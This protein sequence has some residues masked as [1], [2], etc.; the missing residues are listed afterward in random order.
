MLL[1]ILAVLGIAASIFVMVIC[2]L[3]AFFYLYWLVL[4]ATETEEDDD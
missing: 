4:M 1:Q 2:V 3:T